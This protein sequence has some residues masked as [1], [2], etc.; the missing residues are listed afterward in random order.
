MSVN[1]KFGDIIRQYDGQ[2]DFLEW[3]RKLELVAT[4]QDIKDI[5]KFLPLFLSG[6]AF[7]VY[8]SLD[9]EVKRDAGKLSQAL[10][11]A[12]SMNSCAA[13]EA[14]ACRRYLT[15]ESVDV[16]LSELR[17]LARLVHATISDEWI[18]CAFIAGLP[19]DAKKQ[20]Q[21]ASALDTMSLAAVVERA[22]A[23]IGLDRSVGAAA[24]YRPRR[25]AAAVETRTCFRCQKPGHLARECTDGGRRQASGGAQIPRV[26]IVCFTCGE[27]GHVAASSRCPGRSGSTEGPKNE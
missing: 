27:V 10:T 16:Y 9:D 8:E 6:G 18:K 17:R 25:A 12:F 11:N 19:D 24:V 5:E 22:R 26:G 2:G 20:L 14:F 4:L 7:S 15:G 1:V 13:Y 23:L 3:L 21:A